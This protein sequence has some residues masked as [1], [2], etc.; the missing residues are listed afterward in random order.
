[1]TASR[2][3]LTGDKGTAMMSVGGAD[4]RDGSPAAVPEL[5]ELEAVIMGQMWRLEAATVREVLNAV[6]EA[7]TRDRAY[8]T[9]LT[10][11]RRLY[12]KGFLARER[13][14]DRTDVYT[15]AM[16]REHY[17][18]TLVRNRVE[19][20]VGEF[21][22][23]ALANFA[24]Q[25]ERLSPERLDALRKLDNLF[26]GVWS[27]LGERFG[28]DHTASQVDHQPDEPLAIAGGTS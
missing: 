2:A 28:L 16:T 3:V 12:D 26:R 14:P 20:L 15:L 17:F 10:T 6:N 21:G 22:D 11:M 1:M 8:T 25:V 27:D 5:H 9:V 19:A 7:E 24:R 23:L 18:Y 4:H 13:R